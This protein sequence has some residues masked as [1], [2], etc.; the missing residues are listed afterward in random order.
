L[1]RK[2]TVRRT[3][4]INKQIDGVGRSNWGQIS[5]EAKEQAPDASRML[6][7]ASPKGKQ[8]L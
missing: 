2:Q 8:I 4:K 6:A 7:L 3:S 1:E 5:F